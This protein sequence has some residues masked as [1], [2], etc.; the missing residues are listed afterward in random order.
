MVCSEGCWGWEYETVTG[1]RGAPGEGR[2]VVGQHKWYY[3]SSVAVLCHTLVLGNEKL[4]GQS[5]PRIE[6]NNSHALVLTNCIMFLLLT[7]ACIFSCDWM[8]RCGEDN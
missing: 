4:P 2:E 7:L 8:T 1:M 6:V 5:D 3:F